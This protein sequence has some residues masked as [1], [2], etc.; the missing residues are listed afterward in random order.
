MPGGYFPQV[1]MLASRCEVDWT[2]PYIYGLSALNAGESKARYFSVVWNKVTARKKQTVKLFL[3][4]CH[5]F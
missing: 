1:A 3:E 5:Q 4:M 2:S